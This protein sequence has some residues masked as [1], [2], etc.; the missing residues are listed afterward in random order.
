VSAV[1]SGSISD[2]R[3]AFSI[4][5]GAKKKK[6]INILKNINSHLSFGLLTT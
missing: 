5:A 6:K 1:Q 3:A 4:A 2:S